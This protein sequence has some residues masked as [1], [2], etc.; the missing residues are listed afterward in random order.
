MFECIFKFGTLVIKIV[1]KK[2]CVNMEENCKRRIEHRTPYLYSQNVTLCWRESIYTFFLGF[3]YFFLKSL[4]NLV[5]TLMG[6]S[7][8]FFCNVLFVAKF[9]KFFLGKMKLK[10][11]TCISF[12]FQKTWFQ[13]NKTKQ[14]NTQIAWTIQKNGRND[15]CVCVC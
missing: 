13:P 5:V 15:V 12:L 10:H 3:F 1:S 8:C 9:E 4:S 11:T 14:N 2:T 7:F 6:N